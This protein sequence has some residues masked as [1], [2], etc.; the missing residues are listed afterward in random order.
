MSIPAIRYDRHLHDDVDRYQCLSCYKNIDASTR[1]FWAS[2]LTSE[3]GERIETIDMVWKFCP[4][5]GIEWARA[6][7]RKDRWDHDLYEIERES[8]ERAEQLRDELPYLVIQKCSYYTDLFGLKDQP[9]WKDEYGKWYLTGTGVAAAIFDELK[10]Q[11]AYIEKRRIEDSDYYEGLVVKH[12]VVLMR[13]KGKGFVVDQI[14]QEHDNPSKD[15]K[16]PK[17]TGALKALLEERE[18]GW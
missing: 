16:A 6:I 7:P 8:E 14:I 18:E 3:S 9:C 12:R 4:Y 17:Y 15:N 11:R 2:S 10:Q 1:P 13:K 5:C